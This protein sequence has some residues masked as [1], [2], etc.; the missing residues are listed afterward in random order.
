[1]TSRTHPQVQHLVHGVGESLRLSLNCRRL[2]TL[3]C[4]HLTDFNIG[5]TGP[6]SVLNLVHTD[7]Q[8]P[9][10]VSGPLPAGTWLHGPSGGLPSP[11]VSPESNIQSC[12]LFP[13]PRNVWTDTSS[14]ITEFCSAT[15]SSYNLRYMMR[16]KN[17]CISST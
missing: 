2:I 4:P 5:P 16:R 17:S 9:S 1:M 8:Q 6:R 12:C 11:P 14:N 10:L 7:P 15:K 13:R 3:C